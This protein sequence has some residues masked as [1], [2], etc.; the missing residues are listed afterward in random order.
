MKGIINSLIMDVKIKD[1]CVG[2][3][4]VDKEDF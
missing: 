2:T 3:A 4:K 1:V